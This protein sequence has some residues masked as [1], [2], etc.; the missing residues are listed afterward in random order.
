MEVRDLDVAYGRRQVLTG[1]NL[2]VGPGEVLALLGTNGAGKSTLLRAVSGLLRPSAGSVLLAGRDITGQAAHALVRDGLVHV[3][4][5]R[6]V[7]SSLTV[8]DN[9]KAGAHTFAGDRRRV[10]ARIDDA[11]ALFPRLGERLDQRAGALSGGEQ[12]MLAVAKG[13]LLEPRVLLIDELSLGLAPILVG[14]L[15][16]VL[17]QRKAC[18]VTML[19]VEQSLNVAI[20]M[21]DRAVYLDKG[22]IRFTGPTAGLLERA[23]L[24][25]PVFLG[26]AAGPAAAANA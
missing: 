15:L 4:G 11:L 3:C 2:R 26:E 9:L 8:L 5:G 20:S 1:I 25:R 23:D 6:S 18:G 17:S 13:L 10:R 12:Q 22:E 19:I 14:E 24:L 21:A 16:A 7:F